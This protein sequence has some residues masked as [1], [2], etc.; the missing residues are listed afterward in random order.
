MEVLG[1]RRLADLHLA[2]VLL[3]ADTSAIDPVLDL[4]RI[5]VMNSGDGKKKGVVKKTGAVK[6]ID[7]E[8]K[9]GAMQIKRGSVKKSAGVLRFVVV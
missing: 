4:K 3:H 7:A 6:M 8:R 2:A 5:V 9:I 1:D